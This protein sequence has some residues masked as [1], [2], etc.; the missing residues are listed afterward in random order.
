MIYGTWWAPIFNIVAMLPAL[1]IR[2]GI[3]VL[4]IIA[5]VM[6]IRY[7]HKKNKE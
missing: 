5:L 4:V 7:L 6:A 3:P 1:I 2:V